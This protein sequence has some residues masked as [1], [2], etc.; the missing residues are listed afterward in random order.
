MQDGRR[1]VLS[2]AQTSHA[3]IHPAAG[4]L[5]PDPLCVCPGAGGGIKHTYGTQPDR[6]GKAIEWIGENQLLTLSECCYGE[7]VLSSYDTTGKL[8]WEKYFDDERINQII[9]GKDC[10]LATGYKYS[11]RGI[12]IAKFDLKGEKSWERWIR[13]KHMDEGEALAITEENDILILATVMKAVLPIRITL[14]EGLGRVISFRSRKRT[15]FD[16][17]MAV[18]KLNADGQRQWK[19][20][21]GKSGRGFFSPGSIAVANTSQLCV[22]AAYSEPSKGHGTWVVSLTARGRKVFN[23]YLKNYRA[24]P[25]IFQ[26][27]SFWLAGSNATGNAF[28]PDTVSVWQLSGQH[29][30]KA[31]YAVPSRFDEVEVQALQF[32]AQNNFIVAGSAYD[33][34]Y[35]GVLTENHHENWLFKVSS[36]GKKLWEWNNTKLSIDKVNDVVV[37]GEDLFTVGES[38]SKDATDRIL[39]E[40][41]L[42]KLTEYRP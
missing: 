34:Q 3:K 38:W 30:L 37:R 42:M 31:I 15:S 19:N 33:M 36:G 13:I 14:K 7:G 17:Q 35:K 1:C 6:V 2:N 16:N 22:T 27:N 8:I 29:Q 20:V 41:R 4:R 12:W 11:K 9:A 10:F 26:A 32:D 40:M 24:G 28:E 5:F 21:Y 39:Q 25:V 18:L 23:A